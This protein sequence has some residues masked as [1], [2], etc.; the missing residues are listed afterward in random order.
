MHG[1]MCNIRCHYLALHG[2]HNSRD[3]D[4]RVLR[5]LHM[6]VEVLRHSLLLHMLVVG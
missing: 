6:L 4:I 5:V 1:L 2:H 3:L